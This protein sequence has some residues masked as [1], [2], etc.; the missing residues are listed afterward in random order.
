M[1][2]LSSYVLDTGSASDPYKLVVMG[3]DT[4]ASNSID[5]SNLGLTFTETVTAQDATFEVNG[6]SVASASNTVSDAIPGLT[7]S[8]KEPSSSAV[9]VQVNRDE[10]AIS[11]KLQ[12]FVDNY[13]SIINY[14]KVNTTYDAEKGIKGALIGD[15]TVR[16]IVDKLGFMV[17]S[18]YDLGLSYTSLGQMGISTNQDGTLAYDSS[19]FK[20][21]MSENLDAVVSFFTDDAALWE[22]FVIESRMC[23]WTLTRAR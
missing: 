9:S 3:E 10:D 14:Y 8:L 1:D 7:L 17:A 5:L 18:E 15:G 22:A 4:G 6:V 21:K 16:N 2:G 11:N 12:G 13:N 19:V 23:T 20:D